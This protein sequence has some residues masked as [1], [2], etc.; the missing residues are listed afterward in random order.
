MTRLSRREMDSSCGSMMI[1]KKKINKS[2]NS[3]ADISAELQKSLNLS[4]KINCAECNWKPQAVLKN[5]FQIN[6]LQKIKTF[7]IRNQI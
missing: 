3:A 1:E 5:D 4:C 7:P 2:I 6:L